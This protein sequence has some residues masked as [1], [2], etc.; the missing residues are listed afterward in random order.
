MFYQVGISCPSSA[1]RKREDRKLRSPRGQ[2]QRVAGLGR[3][4]APFDSKTVSTSR[5][6][7]HGPHTP[8]GFQ[9]V[10]FNS[11]MEDFIQ[12]AEGC[13]T[14]GERQRH[15]GGRRKSERGTRLECQ[16]PVSMDSLGQGELFRPTGRTRP[17][18][19]RGC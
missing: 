9:A 5:E 14:N 13:Q 2:S 16:N 15:R 1:V 12:E 17:G 7:A 4:S 10:C 18:F 11:F 8:Q 19:P 3:E 6:H